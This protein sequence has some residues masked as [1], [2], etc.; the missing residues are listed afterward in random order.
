MAT[1]VVPDQ[2]AKIRRTSEAASDAVVIL[3]MR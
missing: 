3:K 2:V 1:P